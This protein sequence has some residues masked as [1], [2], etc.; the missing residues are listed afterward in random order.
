MKTGLSLGFFWEFR[1]NMGLCVPGL[2]GLLSLKK[3][4]LGEG[5]FVL[6]GSCEFFLKRGSREIFQS[7][8]A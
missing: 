7:K 4:G 6:M 3:G 1:G 5:F 2:E 8:S